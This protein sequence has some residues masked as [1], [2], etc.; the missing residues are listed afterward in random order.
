[1]SGIFQVGSSSSS[2][3]LTAPLS[4]IDTLTDTLIQTAHRIKPEFYQRLNHNNFW[5]L[6]FMEEAQIRGGKFACERDEP[7]YLRAILMGYDFMLKTL[8]QPLTPALYR[9]LHDT[10]VDGLR[11]QEEPNGVPKGFRNYEDGA[12]SFGLILGETLSREGYNELLEKHRTYAYT[13]EFGD[14]IEV[15][16][17]IMCDPRQ[18]IRFDGGPSC[19]KLKPVRPL[20]CQR[21]VEFCIDL[22]RKNLR[23][24]MAPIR[25][26]AQ[27]CQNLDQAHVFVDGNIR[28]TGILVATKMLLQNGL[29][30]SRLADVNMLDCLSLNELENVFLRGQQSFQDHLST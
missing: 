16:K 15:F 23:E 25:A 30:P 4:E 12:E 18:T 1:M 24:G 11:S 20:T 17:S 19:I 22:Y 6:L 21:N 8:D 29:C 7:G 27:L 14:R 28:T 2:G 5:K 10:C 26:V 13:D 3:N 9:Q